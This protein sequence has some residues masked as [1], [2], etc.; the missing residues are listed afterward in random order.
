MVIECIQWYNESSCPG[1]SQWFG[2]LCNS[3]ANVSSPLLRASSPFRGVIVGPSQA[4]GSQEARGQL[5][6]Q[7]LPVLDTRYSKKQIHVVPNWTPA[8]NMDWRL[9]KTAVRSLKNIIHSHREHQ[10]KRVNQWCV[11]GLEVRSGAWAVISQIRWLELYNMDGANVNEKGGG[12][13]IRTGK[14]LVCH[15]IITSYSN[16]LAPCVW[17]ENSLNQHLTFL[18]FYCYYQNKWISKC[19]YNTCAC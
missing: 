19:L 13:E 2:S 4:V 5:L 12:T 18:F 17:F 11:W 14:C 6:P 9:T 3:L 10:T 1:F 16:K 7:T 15:T 8:L